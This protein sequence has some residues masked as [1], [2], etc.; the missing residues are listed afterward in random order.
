M[1]LSNIILT[2][3][4]VF[5]V[6]FAYKWYKSGDPTFEPL[7]TLLSSLVTAIAYYF[8][9]KNQGDNSNKSETNSVKNSISGNNNV[10]AGGNVTINNPNEKK[11]KLRPIVEI[12]LKM[13]SKGQRNRGY[14]HK[15]PEVITV[16]QGIIH[17][18]LKWEYQF[19][20]HNNSNTTAYNIEIEFE[21]NKLSYLEKL[22]KINNLPANSVK[23]LNANFVKMEE[24]SSNEAQQKLKSKFPPELEGTTI[25]IKYLD[26]ERNSF[27]TKAK[28]QNDELINEI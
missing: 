2:V 8:A 4:S 28:I 13:T 18:E 25:C 5:V 27:T 3:G 11:T 17:F 26:E 21:G 10:Q 12:E 24:C 22:D 14:S 20:I 7:V 1:K 23:T 19:F 15:N 6:F 16:G 9:W